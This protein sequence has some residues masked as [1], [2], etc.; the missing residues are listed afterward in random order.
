MRRFILALAIIP[1]GAMAG[2]AAHPIGEPAPSE[3][4][5]QRVRLTRSLGLA[6]TLHLDEVQAGKM[7]ALM[8]RFDARCQPLRRRHQEVKGFVRRVANGERATVAQTEGAIRDLFD[9]EAQIHQ[10][11]REMFEEISK[12]LSPRESARAAVFL[13][14]FRERFGVP[15]GARGVRAASTRK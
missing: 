10:V 15:A 1:C 8:A 7:R 2:P 14:V 9:L 13:A 6:E 3:I 5:E 11:H 12:D 4:V